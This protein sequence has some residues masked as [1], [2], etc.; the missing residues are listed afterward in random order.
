MSEIQ[1]TKTDHPNKEPHK[2]PKRANP[3]QPQYLTQPNPNQPKSNP[4]ENNK[5][6][7]K[8]PMR[9]PTQSKIQTNHSPTHFGKSRQ[10]FCLTKSHH[11][12]RTI[13]RPSFL[14]EALASGRELRAL[15]EQRHGPALGRGHLAPPHR[16]LMHH[17][18]GPGGQGLKA[19]NF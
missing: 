9:N 4:P 17:L 16:R 3:I 10:P 8:K 7:A 12:N 5:P 11:G 6:F 14:A 13:H 19:P 18:T 1:A 15:L 2:N